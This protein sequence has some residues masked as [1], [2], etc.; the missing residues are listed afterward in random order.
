MKR[1]ALLFLFLTGCNNGGNETIDL[2]NSKALFK[3]SE[4]E[5]IIIPILKEDIRAIEKLMLSNSNLATY[6]EP[7]YG[8]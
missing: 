6:Q 5:E 8:S 2:Y 1:Y 4:A 3:N 7:K